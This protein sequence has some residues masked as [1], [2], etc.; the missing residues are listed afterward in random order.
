MKE[1]IL[2]KTSDINTTRHRFNAFWN[3][4][5]YTMGIT[6]VNCSNG[7]YKHVTTTS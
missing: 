6:Q 7:D 4:V 5:E 2:S 3:Y 1:A